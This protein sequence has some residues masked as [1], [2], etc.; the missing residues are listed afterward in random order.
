MIF[1][2]IY[3]SEIKAP[4]RRVAIGEYLLVRNFLLK[5]YARIFTTAGLSACLLQCI[6]HSFTLM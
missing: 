4:N 6:R 2:Q 1:W 3:H 5:F